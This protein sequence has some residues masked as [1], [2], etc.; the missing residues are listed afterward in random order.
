ML[1]CPI[2]TAH[3]SDSRP[4]AQVERRAE[5]REEDRDQE[6][7]RPKLAPTQGP[8]EDEPVLM[9]IHK[10]ILKWQADHPNITWIGWGIVWMIV[11]VLLF[12]P[13]PSQ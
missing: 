12:W 6:G 8:P 9:T 7:L 10:R 2:P 13:R 4:V 11:L 5:A 3:R 1:S